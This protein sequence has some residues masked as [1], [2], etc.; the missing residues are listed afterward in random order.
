M[1]KPWPS[2]ISGMETVRSG[3]SIRILVPAGM[4]RRAMR[5]R[6]LPGMGWM[7][8]SA[9]GDQCKTGCYQS[10]AVP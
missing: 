3:A 2:T 10:G 8:Y 1:R 5:P 9:V 4:G 7:E 6:P